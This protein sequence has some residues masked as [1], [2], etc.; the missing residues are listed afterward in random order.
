MATPPFAEISIINDNNNNNKNNN[1]N[2]NNNN[3]FD[4]PFEDRTFVMA[5]RYGIE[6]ISTAILLV[7]EKLG[8]IQSLETPGKSLEFHGKSW[9][10]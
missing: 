10:K 7:L 8:K 5:E 2:N 6:L 1:N 9:R 4:L 3:Y